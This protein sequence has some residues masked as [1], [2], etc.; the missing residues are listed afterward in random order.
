[1]RQ[2]L[3][4]SDGFVI[5]LGSGVQYSE[6]PGENQEEGRKGGSRLVFVSSVLTLQCSSFI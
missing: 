1:M 2:L 6:N 3:R 5:G 4:L